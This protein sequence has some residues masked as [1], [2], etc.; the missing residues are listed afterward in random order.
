MSDAEAV[1]AFIEKP[2]RFAFKPCKRCGEMFGTSYRSVAFCGDNCRAR[3]LLETSGIRWNPH[4]PPEERWG[5]E[6]PMILPPLAVKILL[7]AA[8]Q[9]SNE[10]LQGAS[11]SPEVQEQLSFEHETQSDS[12]ERTTAIL[13]DTLSSVPGPYAPEKTNPLESKPSIYSVEDLMG[14][15]SFG[16]G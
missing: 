9:Q 15:I 13:S 6:P 4:K 2:A 5:G 3:Y 12:V 1:L 16:S 10:P 14:G 7:Q 11:E 8:Q